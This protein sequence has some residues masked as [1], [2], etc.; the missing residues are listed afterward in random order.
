VAKFLTVGNLETSNIRFGI[1]FQR[2]F[3]LVDKMQ[4]CTT[5]LV[6]KNDKM[7]SRTLSG[8]SL[9]LSSFSSFSLSN[10][11]LLF[12]FSRIPL[13]SRKSDISLVILSFC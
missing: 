2:C 1:C 5:C 10:Y 13:Y 4:V 9:R 11:L 3:H 8:K 6:F 7:W 12:I